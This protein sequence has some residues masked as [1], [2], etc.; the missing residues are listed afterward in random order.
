MR[1]RCRAHLPAPA[2]AA[3]GA[4]QEMRAV[5]L[6]LVDGLVHIGQRRVLLVLLEAV[7]HLRF[8]ALGQLLEGAHVEAAV[9]K[10]GL[11]FWHVL[12][13][14]AP[15]LADGVAAHGRAIFRHILADEAQQHLGSLLFG[16]R[17]GL[18]LVDQA[19]LA[20]G[21]LVPGVH[22]I[23]HCITLVDHDD[24]AFHARRK[25][26]AGDDHRDLQKKFFF[27]VQTAHFAIEPDQVLVALGEHGGGGN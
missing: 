14:K 17:A 24:R 11:E 2:E 18:D 4:T 8:P 12:H 7:V 21:A 20:V 27:G 10:I 3:T 16:H 9:V 23:Q 22:G 25:V 6:E 19:A 5:V 13:K 15:V 26:G 1:T